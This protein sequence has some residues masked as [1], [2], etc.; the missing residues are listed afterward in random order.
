MKNS[1]FEILNLKQNTMGIYFSFRLKDF[2]LMIPAL[3]AYFMER[4]ILRMVHCL[5][6]KSDQLLRSGEFGAGLWP[7][8][9]VVGHFLT[10]LITQYDLKKGV[11]IGAGVVYSS[12][13]LGVGF[14][15]TGGNLISLEY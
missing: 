1:K 15:R 5:Y 14:Q 13:W 7:V 8:D 11:E 3:Q 6:Y 4:S 12:A 2:I 9:P 10:Y